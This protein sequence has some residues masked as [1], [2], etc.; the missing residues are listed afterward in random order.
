MRL[1]Y[2]TKIDEMHVF[3]DKMLILRSPN[4]LKMK[5]FTL[6]TTVIVVFIAFIQSNKLWSQ[7]ALIEVSIEDQVNN[8]EAIVE[9]KVVDKTTFWDT[10]GENIYTLNRIEVSKVFKGQSSNYIELITEGGAIGLQAQHVSH[11][12]RLQPGDLGI[13]MLAKNEVGLQRQTAPQSDTFKSYS[14]I[15]GFYKYNVSNDIAVNPFVGYKGISNNFYKII[16]GNSGNSYQR[17]TAFNV[18]EAINKSGSGRNAMAIGSISPSVSTAGT[19]DII[20]ITGTGFGSVTGA[21]GFSNSDFGGFAFSD[22]LESQIMSW[23]DTEIQVQVPDFAGTG[24]I[25]ITR[26]DATVITSSEELTIDYAHIN[27]E[28]DVGLGQIAYPTQHVD[29]DGEGGYTWQMYTDFKNVTGA[30]DAFNRAAETWGCGT[31]INW[32]V[33]TDTSVNTIAGDGVNVVRFD[34][35]SELPNGVLGRCTSRFSGCFAADGV[36]INWFV[37]EL[38]IVF[39][40]GVNWNFGTALPLLSQFDFESVALHELGHGRQ[41]GH[42]IN[43]NTIMHFSLSN[44]EESRSLSDN[45]IDGGT[46]VD[47]RSTSNPVCGQPVPTAFSC[48]RLSVE[49]DVLD[50]NLTLYP[51]PSKN[52]IYLKNT[53]NIELQS[54]NIYDVNGRLVLNNKIDNGYNSNMLLNISQLTSGMYFFKIST[55]DAF[56]TKKIVV[57]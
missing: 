29:T 57:L 9:G 49:D 27:A 11:S 38:D 55:E 42:V 52:E 7:S 53:L 15:Q 18:N 31:N 16:E 34:V 46:E 47:T 12:L 2:F 44:G 26:E 10:N 17:M 5:N 51:N 32:K 36:T 1:K 54:I 35:G 33:G 39:D 13:F 23:S 30:E 56:I 25:R 3:N 41:M 4:L 50:Q 6:K 22:A 21:V 28:V 40:D 24:E 20:T 48:S 14:A 8:S 37:T 43:T 19:G 45:D